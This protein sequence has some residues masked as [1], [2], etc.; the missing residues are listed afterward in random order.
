MSGW[1]RTTW[2][3]APQDFSTFIPCLGL[4]IFGGSLSFGSGGGSF[5]SGGA[6]SGL[7]G[8][9]DFSLLLGDG[10]GALFVDLGFSL[11]GSLGSFGSGIGDALFLGGDLR[12]LLG[13]PGGEAALG[14]LLGESALGDTALEMLS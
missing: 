2:P 3:D 9:G 5:F 11:D 12:I 6:G 7:G 14:F 10:L 8:S 1:L 13:L 4:R